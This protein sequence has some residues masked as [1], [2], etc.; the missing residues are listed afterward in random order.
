M[1][2]LTSYMKQYGWDAK[3][4]ARMIRALMVQE[5]A[6]P[7][8]P[9]IDHIQVDESGNACVGEIDPSTGRISY[10]TRVLA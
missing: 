1:E 6:K 8:E 9:G 10:T 5:F 2:T 4:T 3:K 7:R